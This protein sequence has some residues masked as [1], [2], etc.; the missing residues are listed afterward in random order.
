MS[1][2]YDKLKEKEEGGGWWTSYSDLWA[3]LSVVFLLLYVVTSLRS[4]THGVQQMLEYERLQQRVQELEE[5]NRVYSTL[6]EEQLRTSSQ[7]EQ[8]TYKKLMSKLSLLQEEADQEKQELMKQAQEHEEKQFALNQYQQIIRNIIDTNVLA[9]GQIDTRDNVIQD[10]RRTIAQKKAEVQVLQKKV[11]QKENTIARNNEKIDQINNQLEEQIEALREEE[12][13]A[14]VSK[15]AMERT[16]E[17]IKQR[18][19]LKVKELQEKNNEVRQQMM[20]ELEQTKQSYASQMQQI[21]EENQQ[22]FAEEKK[23]FAKKLKKQRLSAKAKRKKLE[24]LKARQE[25]KLK[26]QLASLSS[27]INQTEEQLN[28]ANQELQGTLAKAEAAQKKLADAQRDLASA[29]SSKKAL[30]GKAKEL[31]SELASAKSKLN[32]KKK[33]VDQIKRNFKAAG[34]KAQVDEKTG[35]VTIDFGDEYFDTGKARLKPG[36]VEKLKKLI[37][38]YSQSLFENQETAKRISNIEIIGFASSTYGGKYVNPASLKPENQK[39]INYNLKLSFDRANSIFS[40]IFDPSKMSYKNQK[41]L[42]PMVKVV[43]RGFL[44]EGKEAREIPDNMPQKEFCKKFNCKKAQRVMIKFNL[45][46]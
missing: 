18:G 9:K 15:K 21:R 20:Q 2:D 41:K 26:K 28:E 33:L 16:I 45:K 14:K 42:L 46:D 11:E 35:D 25:A 19:Q 22:K 44:P 7:Q 30:E 34:I 29:E 40:H 39:A 17:R 36:M 32:A 4:G 3:M 1:L 13:K 24:E 8:E 23:A 12:R 5:Q 10:K 43:G 27:K 31:N 6:K 38:A 37:P